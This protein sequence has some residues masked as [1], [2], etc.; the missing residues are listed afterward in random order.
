MALFFLSIGTVQALSLIPNR[1]GKARL[2][3]TSSHSRSVLIE[4]KFHPKFMTPFR[5]KPLNKKEK[6][7]FKE[8][9]LDFDRY[10]KSLPPKHCKIIRNEWR[11]YRQMKNAIFEFICPSKKTSHPRFQWKMDKLVPDKD[12]PAIESI[13]FQF[14][15]FHDEA[16][17]LLLKRNGRFVPKKIWGNKYQLNISL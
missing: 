8:I 12:I 16:G 15:E 1:H 4:L 11:D 6:A 3:I 9:K 5:E 14:D 10:L 2:S 17:L 13:T 7:L